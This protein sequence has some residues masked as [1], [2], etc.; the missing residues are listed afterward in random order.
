M[1]ERASYN[2]VCPGTE[3]FETSEAAKAKLEELNG[4]NWGTEYGTTRINE[5]FVGKDASGNITGYALSVSSKGFGG[6][7]TMALGLTPDGAVNKIAFTELNETAGLGMRA[8]EDSFKDQF[9]GRSGSVAYGTD[10]LEAMSGATVTSTAV[11]NAVNAGLNFY[12]TV[13]KGGN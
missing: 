7:V 3:K 11:K 10:G 6:D 13:M 5:A 8:N 2:E 9:V 12:E 1:A 4:A